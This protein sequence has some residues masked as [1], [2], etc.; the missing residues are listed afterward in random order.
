[1]R[2]GGR[3]ELI[4]P[5]ALAYKSVSQASIPANS[6]LIFIVDL[7]GVTPASGG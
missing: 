7:L 1:M 4:I 6:T 5:P 3:R 2:V